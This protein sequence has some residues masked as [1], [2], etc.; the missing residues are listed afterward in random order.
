[1]VFKTDQKS[2]YLA[3][4]SFLKYIYLSFWIWDIIWLC[5]PS[6]NIWK[7][8]ANLWPIDDQIREAFIIIIV[9]VLIQI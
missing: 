6:Q 8:D 2:L 5:F 4:L 7:Y 3:G 1:M 9:L